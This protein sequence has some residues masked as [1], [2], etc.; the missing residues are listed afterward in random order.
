MSWQQLLAGRKVQSHRTSK[1]EIDGL[2]EIVARDLADA[3]IAAL[4]SDRRFATAYNAVLQLSKMAIASSG[5]R[6]SVG[7][8]HHQNTFEAVKAALGKPGEKLADYF[9]T[10][11]RKRNKIDYDF[12]NVA[13]DTEAKELLKKAR[14]FETLVEKWIESKH[15][16]LKA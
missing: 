13:T 15:P 9:E 5:Y 7:A 6:V 12:S 16:S 11:R 1:R 2:R 4:S 8:G 14:E 10:C 3:S